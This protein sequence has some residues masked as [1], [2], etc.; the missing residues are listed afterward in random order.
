MEAQTAAL[1][2]ARQIHG[3]GSAQATRQQAAL[4]LLLA[5]RGDPLLA[6]FELGAALAAERLLTGPV[7]HI[8]PQII[9]AQCLLDTYNR[10]EVRIAKAEERDEN[11]KKSGRV[12]IGV[13][14]DFKKCKPFIKAL[15]DIVCDEDSERAQMLQ[16][17]SQTYQE[18]DRERRAFAASERMKQ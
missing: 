14:V 15:Q 17:E 18:R 10:N 7:L 1:A 4:G 11:G 12:Q 2:A 6:E 3:A 5:R 8:Y 16:R 9:Q 13:I